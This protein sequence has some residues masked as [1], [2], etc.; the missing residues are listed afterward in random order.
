LCYYFGHLH[1]VYFAVPGQVEELSLDPGSDCITVNW[2]KPIS[3]GDCVTE[4]IIEWVNNLSGREGNITVS[5]DEFSYNI[6]G[7]DACVEYE[8]S[9]RADVVGAEAATAIETT[10]TAG[11]YHTHIISLFSYRGAHE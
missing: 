6:T 10:Q 3:N 5:K 2:K 8:V 4:Y 11:N 9:V 1:V 7:L